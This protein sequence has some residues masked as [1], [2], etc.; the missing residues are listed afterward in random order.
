MSRSRFVE[1]ITEWLL[2]FPQTAKQALRLAE[3][4]EFDD[5]VRESVAGAILQAL[6]GANTIPGVRG[7]LA[8]VDDI[9]LLKLAFEGASKTNPDIFASHAKDAPETLGELHE[10][11]AE[12][13]AFVGPAFSLLDRAFEGLSKVQYEGHTAHECVNDDEWSRWLYDEVNEAATL[14]FDLKEEELRRQMKTIDQLLGELRK[15]ATK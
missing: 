8:Y 9:I 14:R 1:I 12:L 4:P 5:S 10:Q 13:R 2:V 6:S 11:L 3:D 15:A 7:M